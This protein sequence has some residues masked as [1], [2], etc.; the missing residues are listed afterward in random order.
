MALG[1]VVLLLGVNALAIAQNKRPPPRLDK[2]FLR[3]DW[4]IQSSAKVHEKGDAISQHQFRPKG[5]YPASVPS[6]VVG[7][8]VDDKVYPDPLVGMNLRLIP[9]CNYPIG[10][11]FSLRPMPEDSPFRVSWWYRTEFQLPAGYR[12][13]NIWLH[14]DGV[15]F[16]ANI[17]LNGKQIAGSDQIAGTF[18]LHELNIRDAIHVGQP[19]TLAV[20]VFPALPDDLGW[21]WVDWNPMPPDKNM[22]IFRDVYL[23]S[24]GPLTL[25]YPQ[26]VTHFDLPS[27]TTAHLTVNA[28]AHNA[29]GREVEGVLSGRIEG[30]RF[31]QRVKLGPQETRSVSFTPD[32]FPQLN[33]LHPRV[34]WPV[35]LGA[36][37]L[38]ALEMEFT[39]DGKVSDRQST[40]FGIREITS[41]LDQQNHLLFKVN[42]QNVLIRGGGWASDMFL[43][44]VP[45]RLKTEFQYV[46]DMNLNTI[47][48][49]GQLQ[50]DYFF[51][52]ADE[53]GILIMAGWCCCSHWEHWQ[54]RDDYKEG[55]VWDKGDYDIAAK[56][57]ADQIKRLRNHPSLLVWLNGSDN[58]P[59]PDVE[60]MYIDILKRYQWPN[61]FLSSATA[62]P[63]SVTGATGVKMEGP[64]EWVPAN[65]WLLDKEAGGA[66]G[67]ATEISPG[68]A[69]PPIESLQRM[70]P[71]DHLW[72]IDDYWNYHAGGGQ[73]KNLDVFTA[74]LNARYGAAKDVRD[75]AVKS[76]LMTY[77]GQRAMFESYAGNRYKSTG[78]IQWMLNNAWPSLIWH[79]YDYYLMPAGGYF[80]TKKA[81]EPIHVQYS[82]DD[83]SVMAVNT[84]YQAQRKLRLTAQVY[85]INLAE[86]FS[87]VAEFDLAPDSNFKAFLIP[88]ISDL[89]ATYFLKLTLQDTAGQILSS[90]F[91]WL[92]TTDDVLDKKGTKW[93]YTPVSSYADMT[94]LEKLP[95]VKLA[96]AGKAVRRGGEEIAHVT[97]SNP[98]H[99]LAFFVH[100]Q[101]KQGSS[102]RDVLPVI[103]Q[104]NYVS[105]LPG[106]RREL[107]ATYKVKD[108]GKVAAFLKVEG[109]NSA[110]VKIPLGS[111]PR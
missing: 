103:W 23:T 104:D 1:F 62:K 18:R 42:G 110:P 29:T 22:G 64:Y 4:T 2:T 83:K 28:E 14:L 99:N 91:Y 74:A 58:P 45:D 11:N 6:T 76:Q 55:P 49:E 47:R 8:L 72:P 73:F 78:V 40:R 97:L 48:L 88:Q 92:S 31:S 17:W 15:N 25:R 41:E 54:H 69:V 105:L 61:P 66:H 50:P 96:V 27:L 13:Q 37:N 52:L 9:G 36:Q 90:N 35:H 98:T 77:E 60:Q 84:T 34:W 68:P 67:F 33:L 65:Y 107:T 86:K 39:V 70:I 89:S 102:E 111:R 95:P 32:Q 94:Q 85:D 44:F 93:F 19:N 108:L 53:Y 100:L 101:I 21:T 3:E 75:Y 46:K 10:A 57:Q 38:Y 87:Q 80:G 106:E 16:R 24:S 109:W 82:Y 79:L 26:A 7:T 81:C 71:K 20:E 51:D 12:D 59:P 30:I 56:S 5:W 43:R 63:T